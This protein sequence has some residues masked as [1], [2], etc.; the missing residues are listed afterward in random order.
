[1]RS[2]IT[3]VAGAIIIALAIV[4][5]VIIS[6]TT[7]ASVFG[8]TL[9]NGI[10]YCGH[11]GKKLVGGYASKYRSCYVYRRPIYRC[12]NGGLNPHECDGPRTYSGSK[13]EMAVMEVVYGYFDTIRECVNEAW[14]DKA[15]EHIRSGAQ[16]RQKQSVMSR[17]KCKFLLRLVLENTG[18]D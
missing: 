7:K 4:S 14:K 12:Y 1:M 13:L 5:M 16:S 9:L 3:W 8:A 2:I 15:R 6:N 10:L 18:W 17:S 11:C